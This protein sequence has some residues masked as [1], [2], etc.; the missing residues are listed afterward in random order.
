MFCVFSL[1]INNRLKS[2][3]MFSERIDQIRD[4]FCFLIV[5]YVFGNCVV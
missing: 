3:G 4:F 1:A 5:Q 2:P